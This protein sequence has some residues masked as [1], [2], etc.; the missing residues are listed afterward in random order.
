MTWTLFVAILVAGQLLLVT[1]EVAK[2]RRDL[3]RMLF[4]RPFCVMA[5]AV[6]SSSAPPPSSSAPSPP[7]PSEPTPS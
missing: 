1:I 5:A 2:I 6:R 3:D 7:P 4:T